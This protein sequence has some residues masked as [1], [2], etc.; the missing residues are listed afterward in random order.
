MQSNNF[1]NNYYSI[2]DDVDQIQEHFTT[3]GQKS[4]LT[5]DN[6][7]INNDR[8]NLNLVEP[9][10][11]ITDNY[12]QFHNLSDIIENLEDPKQDSKQEPKPIPKQELKPKSKQEPKPK[13]K[14]KSKSKSKPKS[15]PKSKKSK[16]PKS[17]KSKKSKPK[18][19]TSESKTSCP[20][21][22]IAGTTT[23]YSDMDFG[24]HSYSRRPSILSRI[25]SKLS[26]LS[27][28]SRCSGSLSDRLSPRYID[29][30]DIYGNTC[31]VC[32]YI[33]TFIFLCM[34]YHIFSK[35]Y[36]K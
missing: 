16:K 23:S 6:Y 5:H 8:N 12:G 15:K 34:I 2:V 9:F 11:G 32:K 4:E 21:I 33:T 26:S 7:M 1:D 22:I 29:E 31:T 14:S 27:S 3:N 35:Y 30:S 28:R 17:K 19:S 24:D 25:R 10:G 13:P 18:P 20:S 36:K